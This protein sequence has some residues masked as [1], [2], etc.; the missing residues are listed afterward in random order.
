MNLCYNFG[1]LRF[2]K[3]HFI[4]HEGND[5]RPHFLRVKIAT[6]ML[7]LILIIEGLYIGETRIILPK[8]DYLAAIFATVLVDQTNAVRAA[9]A[10][11][12]LTPSPVLAEVARMKAED[13]AAKGYFSH[14]TPDGK[15]PWYWFRLAGY[16]YVAAG[17][18][19][20]VNF[21]DSKDVTDAWMNSPSHRANIENGKYTEI[22][23]AT[24]Q[25]VYKGREAIFV[26][27]VFGLPA[28]AGQPATPL[29]TTAPA[30]P[31]VDLSQAVEIAKPKPV[32]P[33][34][35]PPLETPTP[36]TTTSVVAGAETNTLAEDVTPVVNMANEVEE[37]LPSGVSA[38]TVVAASPAALLTSP[39]HLATTFYFIL[40]AI[41]LLALGLAIFIKREI[42]YP[43]LVVGGFLLLL[44]L[45][46]L[47]IFNSSTSL[48]Q[49]V[50]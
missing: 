8:S 16:Q 41:L 18:N 3:D 25:G 14:N 10:L 5:Y 40:G 45:V 37:T 22:G 4:P 6:G 30:R 49:G 44:V 35:K 9:E 12:T 48:A 38:A 21:T 26:V 39:R 31:T 47:S 19:L 36:L 17:E 24:A 23:I 43:R 46:S 7:A 50:I 27:Q 34:A 11:G 2:L 13:M 42:Q 29:Q 33:P 20:A 28:Q 1:M 32:L 15:T